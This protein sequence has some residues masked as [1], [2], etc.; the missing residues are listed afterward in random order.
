MKMRSIAKK[1]IAV[2]LTF[3]IF[4]LSFGTVYFSA[5]T[6]S[7]GG[8][9]V[10]SSAEG[11]YKSYT[12]Y[13]NEFE[14]T[15]YSYTDKKIDLS[16][17][18][19]GD[20]AKVSF[21]DYEGKNNVLL[22]DN[23]E[24]YIE[25]NTEVEKTGLYQIEI[26]YFPVLSG[27]N[28]DLAFEFLLDYTVLFKDCKQILLPK[29]YKD[30]TYISAQENDFKLDN[31]GNEIMPSQ[32]EAP[33][34]IN[35]TFRDNTCESSEAFYF[36][37]TE[38]NHNI[39]LV[40]LGSPVA[41]SGISLEGKKNILSHEEYLENTDKKNAVG[42][43]VVIEAEKPLNKTS[44]MLYPQQD[45]SDCN[46]T[47]SNP[48]N[49][50][51]NY[52]GGENWSHPT[53]SVTWE[54]EVETDGYYKIGFRYKQNFL[55]EQFTS[56]A[57]KIDG[58]ILFEELADVHFPYAISWDFTAV[59]GNEPLQ[60]FLTKGR[61]TIELT[62]TLSNEW[63]AVLQEVDG[64]TTELNEIYK[65]II[66][67]TGVSPDIYR[68]YKLEDS[69]PDLIKN[70]KKLSKALKSLSN[71]INEKS[72]K[73]GGVTSSIDRLV[74]QLESFIEKPD[75]I[76]ERISA[77]KGN[78]S[79][80]SSWVLNMR[81]QSLMLDKIYIT[82]FSNE[83]PEDEFG[84]FG[85]MFYKVKSFLY[86]FTNDYSSIGN[87]YY[88]ENALTIWLTGARD[89]AEILKTKID[90]EFVKTTKI[91]VNAN[92]STTTLISA[93]MADVAP[94][95][96]LSV[97]HDIPVNLAMRGAA[98]PLDR[99]AGFGELAEEFREG[100]FLPYTYK[101]K[102]YGIPVTQ[103]F[104]MM[105]YRTDILKEQELSVPA[106][107]DELLKSAAILQHQNMGIGLPYAVDSFFF[108]TLLYQMGG[109]MYNKD[110]TA[111]ELDT[112]TAYNA[113]RKWTD[114]YKQS[115]FDL[116]KDDLTRFRN[117][118]LPIIV[119]YYS[120]Y[121][122]L[123]T[124]APEIRNMWKMVPIPG[125]KNEDGVIDN[126]TA[127]TGTA[128]VILSS[129][130]NV[131]DAWEFL[132]WWCCGETQG[133]YFNQ[134]ESMLG[135]VARGTP[136]NTVAFNKIAWTNEEHSMLSAQWD[137]YRETEEIPGSYYLQ[138]NIDNAFKAVYYNDDN[139]REALMYW[140]KE[141]NNE[142]E[143]KYKEFADEGSTS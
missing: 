123:Q 14:N 15:P 87:T 139:P 48:A 3:F 45:R 116:Y 4:L 72:Q 53:Q 74:Q 117:G 80:L 34:W 7:E 36:Y 51:L 143:R 109:K 102:C 44:A 103:N 58:E 113:F 16:V 23:T 47:P 70:C 52:I 35:Y 33:E 24:G 82:P 28:A 112:I 68:D 40:N 13:I 100:A 54:F 57:V 125:M 73:E 95:V 41:I 99:M 127:A 25:F 31:S 98:V 108:P 77:F 110:L 140:N 142:I 129:S 55:Y 17:F 84:F 43:E 133:D 104:Y 114:F 6:V 135:T 121:N 1:Y 126:T 115:G 118:E 83:N 97:T 30:A 20:N 42:E 22:W 12:E 19:T 128:A 63:Q 134:V 60:V 122:Q 18:A 131:E 92:I 64:Y 67:I 78:I 88:S 29:L 71:K 107:W 61:H 69:I 111:T 26:E 50:R 86:T 141:I 2:F 46:T 124:Y 106:T 89:Q 105:F 5:N 39:R 136:A 37:F 32:T 62:P 38:G 94:D 9:A 96:A 27:R 8:T 81:N 49:T 90:S 137:N 101:N 65:Q 66:Y 10:L 120:F 75:T 21:C 130:E 79:S 91:E 11:E 119:S 138:R 59:G 93:M 56:R 132:K 76:P 85:N